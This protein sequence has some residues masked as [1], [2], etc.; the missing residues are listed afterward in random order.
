MPFTFSH[1]A[2]VLPFYKFQSNWF[3]LTGLIAGSISPDFEYYFRMEKG[4]TFYSH[5]LLSLFYFNL[6][7]GLLLSF[8]FHAI[9]R[10]PLLRNLTG[11]FFIRFSTFYNVDWSHIFRNKF[12]TLVISILL[13]GITHLLWDGLTHSIADFAYVNQYKIPIFSSWINHSVIYGAI[14][15][16]FSLAGLFYLGMVLIKMKKDDVLLVPKKHS[17]FWTN[18][19]IIT[20]LVMMLKYFFSENLS[21]EDLQVSVIS[22]FLVGILGSCLLTLIVTPKN[23]ADFI[24]ENAS[25][26]HKE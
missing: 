20:I 8:L 19:S 25:L 11:F 4:I 21:W 15:I 26:H 14:H 16:L 17:H 24:Q 1:P 7:V 10:K 3:S 22:A 6:P 2:L 18:I 5:T 12:F 9:V 13:G 23:K